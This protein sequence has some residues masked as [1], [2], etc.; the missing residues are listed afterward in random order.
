MLL[1]GLIKQLQLLVLAA[2]QCPAI[3]CLLVARQP[4]RGCLGQ[5]SQFFL[6]LEEGLWLKSLPPARLVG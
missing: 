1:F 5:G 6:M 3:C 4:V 2:V